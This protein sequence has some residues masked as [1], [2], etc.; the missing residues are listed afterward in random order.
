MPPRRG[1]PAA[2]LAGKNAP[3]PYPDPY[4]DTLRPLRL[5]AV[6]CENALAGARGACGAATALGLKGDPGTSSKIVE[7][8]AAAPAPGDI[9]CVG[10]IGETPILLAAAPVPCVGIIGETPI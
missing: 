5:C 4:P 3:D 9:P 1:G 8:G 2:T 6:G 7:R 10:I